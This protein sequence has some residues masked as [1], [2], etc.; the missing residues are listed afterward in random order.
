MKADFLTVACVVRRDLP[1]PVPL[2]PLSFCSARLTLPSSGLV[3]E[4]ARQGLRTGSRPLLCLE[5][6]A[7]A[8]PEGQLPH[9]PR[10]FAPIFLSEAL[11]W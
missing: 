4:Q 3:P 6:S 2:T 1:P 7:P 10:V 8:V 5:Y 9:L 11:K